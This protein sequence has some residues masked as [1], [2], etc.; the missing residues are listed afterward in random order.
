MSK[1]Q[2]SIAGDCACPVQ[3]L[4]NLVCRHIELT[5]KF[6]GAHVEGVKFFRELF[7]WMNCSDRYE[8]S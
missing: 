6:C 4:S 2:R 3:D 8:F 5:R 7:A 1:A